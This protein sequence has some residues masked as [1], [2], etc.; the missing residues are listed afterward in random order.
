[1]SRQLRQWSRGEEGNAPLRERRTFA[2]VSDAWLPILRVDIGKRGTWVSF[3]HF[4]KFVMN[5]L[6][7]VVSICHSFRS[8]GQPGFDRCFQ[9]VDL[10]TAWR[11]RVTPV[12][13]K[14]QILKFY[15]PHMGKQ[16]PFKGIIEP[17][18]GIIEPHL[19]IIEPL[20]GI[21]KPDEGINK[22]YVGDFVRSSA[23][24]EARTS[25]IARTSAKAVDSLYAQICTSNHLDGYYLKTIFS[26]P[27]LHIRTSSF[28]Y[29]YYLRKSLSKTFR[30]MM[31]VVV[32]LP[33][34]CAKEFHAIPK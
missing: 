27:S 1:M 11:H 16:R 5:F 14:T 21:T 33:P 7:G 28:V 19:G 9:V 22:P 3:F 23:A 30:A 6:K 18:L 10:C 20:L 31:S 17:R 2:F 4:L 29:N 25:I 24:S 12:L 13:A 15:Q 26:E 34:S 32:A 8:T